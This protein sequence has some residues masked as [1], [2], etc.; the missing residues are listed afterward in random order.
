MAKLFSAV[1]TNNDNYHISREEYRDLKYVK[2]MYIEASLEE[3]SELD[4]KDELSKDLEEAID[5]DKEAVSLEKAGMTPAK[6]L[7]ISR[8]EL[9][10]IYKRAGFPQKE[11]N[12]IYSMSR[13][14]V[15]DKKNGLL[16]F[17]KN[18]LENVIE[19]AKNT[20]T[21]WTSMA[22]LLLGGLK[23]DGREDMLALRN[24]INNDKVKFHEEIDEGI[25]NKVASR[26]GVMSVFEYSAGGDCSDL[27][28]YLTAVIDLYEPNSGYIKNLESW[29]RGVGKKDLENEFD[30]GRDDQSLE[31]MDRI[32]CVDFKIDPKAK[33]MRLA[34]Y[35]N[36]F[37]KKCM[38]TSVYLDPTLQG[39][40]FFKVDNETIDN[41]DH[42]RIE[43]MTKEGALALI[44]FVEDNRRKI[45]NIVESS[46]RYESLRTGSQLGNILKNIVKNYSNLQLSSAK[47]MNAMDRSVIINIG[48]LAELP[49]L[50]TELIEI[51][52]SE[53]PKKGQKEEGAGK[54]EE[55]NKAPDTN[56]TSK[57]N[58]TDKTNDNVDK[59]TSDENTEQ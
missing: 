31:L 25:R 39:Y 26:I 32:K 12:K 37:T 28:D 27:I 35:N 38:I 55:D 5:T 47:Y 18:P 41:T 6:T 43:P 10:W 51:F 8:E 50:V 16:G 4:E 44:Q 57:D 1:N 20:A 7:D 9:K 48:H 34:I 21:K 17:I 11:I 29:M 59:E 36:L 53:F 3:M 56:S 15:I 45:I 23:N 30:L 58:D 46:K 19:S 52:A 49:K 22:K 14:E 54:P 42:M 24:N 40:N 2:D 13:E 33:E